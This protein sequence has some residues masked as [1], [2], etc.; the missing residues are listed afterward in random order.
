M[1]GKTEIEALARSSA[2]GGRLIRGFSMAGFLSKAELESLFAGAVRT[3]VISGGPA[4]DHTISGIAVG[5]A[6]RSV[7]KLDIAQADHPLQTHFGVTVSP[8]AAAALEGAD[9]AATQADHATAAR[10]PDHTLTQPNDHPALAHARTW[11]VADLTGEFTV[12]GANTITN[13]GGTDTTGAIL[14]V[15]FEDL[16]P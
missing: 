10:H 6:L 12:T 8:H 1:I 7:L 4:G 3:K 15:V 16:T 5:D 2:R 9:L 11:S 14:V 13:A